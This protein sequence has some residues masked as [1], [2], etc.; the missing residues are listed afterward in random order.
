VPRIVIENLE[1]AYGE[2]ASRTPAL[3]GINLSLEPNTL[4]LLMGPSGSGKT[5]LLTILGALAK[6][7]S[8]RVMIDDIDLIQMSEGARAEFRRVNI[9]FIFQSFRLMNALTAEENIR[10]SLTMRGIPKARDI[11][12]AALDA[13]GLDHKRSLLPKELSG[14]EKQR[15]AVARALAHRPSIILADEPTASLDSGNGARVAD[16]LRSAL[17]EAGRLV[18]V[19]THDDRLVR[20]AHRMVR[21]EDGRILKDEMQ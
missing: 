16:L 5:S 11:T 10:M 1:I 20:A 8:G 17:S 2:G 15:V 14:G 18:L 7:D 4:T 3:R 21:I 9:G 19:V 13:V 6:P 12:H